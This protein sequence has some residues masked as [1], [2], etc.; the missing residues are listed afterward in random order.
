M[1][2]TAEH[3][4]PLRRQR[5]SGKF[6]IENFTFYWAFQISDKQTGFLKLNQADIKSRLRHKQKDK[7]M[8]TWIQDF[9]FG[10]E[11]FTD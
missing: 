10:N 11:V 6:Q 7:E 5:E 4:S 2:P 1:L 8:H 9:P 3:E